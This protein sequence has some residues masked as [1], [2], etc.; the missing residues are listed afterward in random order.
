M[1][2]VRDFIN[3]LANPRLFFI[4]SVAALLLIIWK[5]EQFASK[6][7]GY[8][9]LGFLALFLVFGYFDPNFQLIILKPDNVPIVGLI[10]LIV[11]FTWYSIRQASS[12]T[13]VSRAGKDRWKSRSRI[14]CGCGPIWSTRN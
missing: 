4:L 8:G 7:V 2:V 3:G 5:R 11:F 12:T 1:R 13:S 9:L 14:A 6:A 10:F